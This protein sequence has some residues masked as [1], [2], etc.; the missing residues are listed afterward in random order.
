MIRV[1]P[2]IFTALHDEKDTILIEVPDLE[3]LTEGFGMANAVYMARDAIGIKGIGC[4][5]EGKELPT[6][7][8][9]ESIDVSQGTFAEDGKGIVSLVDVDFIE[10]RRKVDNRAVRRN[11][12]LPNWLDLE[13]EKAGINVSKVLQEALISTLNVSENIE[14]YQ[15]RSGQ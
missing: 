3:I 4:E 10:Y 13:A 7:S 8:S 6:P 11:V 2:V 12:T 9:I 1:Y 14:R 15:W 5:D